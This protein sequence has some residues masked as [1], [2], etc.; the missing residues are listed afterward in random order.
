MI[1]VVILGGGNLASHL[2]NSLL[3]NKAI[4]L[5]QVYN[6]SVDKIQYLKSKTLIT[7]NLNEL[8]DAD[9]YVIAISDNAISD[10]SSKLNFKNKLVVHTSGAANLNEL[11]SDSNKGVFYP[12]QTFSKENKIDFASIPICIEAETNTDLNLLEKLAKTISKKCYQI[13]S[14]QRKHLHVAAVFVN[15]FVNHLYHIGNEI[16]EENGIPFEIL[17]PIIEKTSK[18]IVEIAP[19]KAQT[20][21]AKRNDT[22]TI[23]NHKAILNKQQKE[24]YELLTKSIQS[25]YGKKL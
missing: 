4:K 13:N 10:V 9:I 11:K 3:N 18:K 22:K 1:K 6:R 21:P 2:T 7:D 5:I 12:L 17:H 20:G 25:T 14:E 8:E 15:N 19:L 23:K 16:C 24:I